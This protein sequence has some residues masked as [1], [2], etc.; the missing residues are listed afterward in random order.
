MTPLG[1][2]LN[3]DK[4]TAR[5]LK[6]LT[7]EYTQIETVY[8]AVRC[9]EG[10]RLELEQIERIGLSPDELDQRSALLSSGSSLIVHIPQ[11]SALYPG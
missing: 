7:D 1:W 8:A 10:Y 4:I 5:F 6:R 9:I 11:D 2:V 3:R